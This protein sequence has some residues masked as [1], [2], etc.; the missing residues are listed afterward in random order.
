MK[1]GI[2]EFGDAGVDTLYKYMKQLH[3]L[4]V[5]IPVDPL[6]LYSGSKADALK[7]LMFLNMKRYGKVKYRICTD[8]RYQQYYTHKG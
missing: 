2:K 4:R 3:D 8:G 6:N 1:Q 5:P 7:Y